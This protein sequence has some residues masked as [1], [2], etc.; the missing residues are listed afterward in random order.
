ME[1]R[2]FAV[3]ISAILILVTA[4]GPSATPQLTAFPTPRP[5]LT[6]T[7]TLALMWTLKPTPP[8]TPSLTPTLG[9]TDQL[10]PTELKYRLL[11]T[12]GEIFFCDPDYY[13]VARQDEKELA[14][15]K[16]PEVQK[17]T[18]EFTAIL[19]QKGLQG[20]STFSDDQKLLIYREHKKLQG[21]NLEPTAEGYEFTLTIPRD[22]KPSGVIIKG[23]ITRT[24]SISISKEEPTILTCPICL[25]RDVLIDTPR[26]Q[27]AVA[28]LKQGM[29]IWTVN[30]SGGRQVGMVLKA[31]KT[32][33][34]STHQIVHLLLDDGRALFASPG[35][36][37]A[38]GRIIG[39]LAE[40]DILD[41]ARVIAAELVSYKDAYT[42]DI[43][44]SGETG[45]Y[46]VNGILIGSSLAV[47]S[48]RSQ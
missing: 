32:P 24:G 12:F 38:D 10:S 4:C 34:P 3:S 5:N 22:S 17:N 25:A 33:V 47:A 9:P 20:T 37:T 18:E 40:G 43:L 27:V 21:I 2:L 42:Y 8:P 14:L 45:A 1:G 16:F 41:A 39:D 30:S 11:E 48:Y 35:H 44:P 29:F 31:T 15:Q 23:S 28:D 26:G 36:P 19:Q 13:P 7:P 6:P 46:W